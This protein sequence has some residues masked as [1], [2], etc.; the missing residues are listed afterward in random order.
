MQK[1]NSDKRDTKDLASSFSQRSKKSIF[2]RG[3]S[4]KSRKIKEV[5]GQVT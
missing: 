3:N 5:Y 1:E 4:A 2:E